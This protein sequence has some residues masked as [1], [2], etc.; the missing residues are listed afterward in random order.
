MNIEA[1]RR[2]LIESME[3]I[4]NAV[5]M[6]IERKQR[7]IGFHC[8]AAAVDMLEIFLHEK[9]L[10]NPGTV[11]KHD[12]FASPRKATDKIP[13][14]QGKEKLL[15]LFVELEIRRNMLVYGKGQ[16]RDK[17]ESYL[18]LFNKIK[19]ILTDMGVEYE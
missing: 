6:G 10:I 11:I 2:A 13:S 5:Q 15:K 8:S 17:I 12:F 19:E 18:E 4:R 3:E 7:T 9:N 16:N 14:F 1:H